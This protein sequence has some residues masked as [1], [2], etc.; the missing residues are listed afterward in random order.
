MNTRTLPYQIAVAGCS[1]L[2]IG[3]SGQKAENIALKKQLSDLSS[4]NL[5][6]ETKV[7]G[8]QAKLQVT[9]ELRASLQ[10]EV[11][12]LRSKNE[13]SKKQIERLESSNQ[14]FSAKTV[15]DKSKE[16]ALA[17]NMRIDK[18]LVRLNRVADEKVKSVVNESIEDR[19]KEKDRLRPLA[20]AEKSEALQLVAE[21]SNLEF[22]PA[23]QIRSQVNR[24]FGA[25]E[26]YVHNF[27]NY[28]VWEKHGAD[29]T[30]I[31]IM[32]DCQRKQQLFRTNM[33]QSIDAIRE[34]KQKTSN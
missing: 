3:C 22:E 34:L 19:E 21:L 14:L 1:L 26:E 24:F 4:S 13:E 33:Q 25:R 30:A 6:L 28:Y 10:E 32:K 15:F 27:L 23:D 5:V 29:D 12:S 2:L 9:E 31:S 7:L 18:I 16:L 8:L 17:A 11:I 20:D